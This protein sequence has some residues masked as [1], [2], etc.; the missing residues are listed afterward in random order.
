MLLNPAASRDVRPAPGVPALASRASAS[1]SFVFLTLPAAAGCSWSSQSQSGSSEHT[2]AP[3]FS[4]VA[5]FPAPGLTLLSRGAS[6]RVRPL[7]RAGGYRFLAPKRGASL[8]LLFIFRYLCVA[9]QLPNSFLN[10]H[11]W[12]CSFVE[13]QMY[14]PASQA[15]S[16]MF[17]LV[18]Y[19]SSS[20]QGTG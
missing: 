16:W 9:S 1:L 14:L 10:T 6:P 12:R 20:T 13:I 17:R 15:D 2:G 7:P 3:I 4:L 18:W 8:P 19:L 11:R 5:T